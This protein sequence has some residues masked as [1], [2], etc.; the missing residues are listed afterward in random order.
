VH[1]LTLGVLGEIGRVDLFFTTIVLQHNPPPVIAKA[2]EGLLGCLAEGG[3]G[4]FQVPTYRLN[5]HFAA[6]SWLEAGAA[7]VRNMEMH[8]LPQRVLFEIFE[9]CGCRVIEVAEDGSTGIRNVF[10]SNVFLVQKRELST[11]ID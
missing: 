4:Y 3:Y 11:L 9:R 6:A 1:G 8:S 5:Y 10:R 7:G 2:V